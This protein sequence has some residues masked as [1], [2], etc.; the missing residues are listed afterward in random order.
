MLIRLCRVCLNSNRRAKF[1]GISPLHIFLKWIDICGT[2][3]LTLSH[4]FTEQIFRPSLR[5][6][7]SLHAPQILGFCDKI[8]RCLFVR[9]TRSK[10]I[11]TSEREWLILLIYSK[12]RK[13]KILND[14][15]RKMC[16]RYSPSCLI[17]FC[18]SI[19]ECVWFRV[20]NLFITE[21]TK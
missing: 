19:T 18:L 11:V 9:Y 21:R 8:F 10:H 13:Y 15:R 2:Q 3:K 4:S 1:A 16:R 12:K 20:S 14:R 7:I 17:C 6:N 5:L